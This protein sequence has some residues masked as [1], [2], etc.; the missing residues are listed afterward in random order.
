MKRSAAAGKSASWRRQLAAAPE[1]SRRFTVLFV[2]RFYRR[3]RLQ[4]LLEAAASLQAAIPDL[5]VRIVG[6]GPCNAMW[7]AAARR[8]RLQDTVTWL[9]DVTRARLAAEYNRAHVF[10]LPSVQ[11]GF[12][13]V[14]LEAMAAGKP[15][16][17]A[18]AAA[19]PEVAPH[20]ALV[21]PDD[22]HALAGAILDLHNSPPARAAQSA[23]GRQWVERFDARL[24][25][26]QFVEAITSPPA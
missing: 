24:V 16:A 15:V 7:R 14:L 17:A 18:R 9:G 22:A 20:A 6:N 8:L 26:R 12:G 19:I 13:I 10:C 11:E 4:L 25:A 1:E 23:R 3:K 5:E 21:E 2:G